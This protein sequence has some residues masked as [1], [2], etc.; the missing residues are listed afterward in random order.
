[1]KRLRLKRCIRLVQEK[2]SE[3]LVEQPP[4]ELK[5]VNTAVVKTPRVVVKGRGAN[6]LSY[7][8]NIRSHDASFGIGPAGT[9]KTYRAVA[10]AVEALEHEDGQRIILTRPAVEAGERLSFLPGDLA[11]KIDPYLRP[12]NDALS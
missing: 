8:H 3:V 6:Q 9:G 10:W 2:A 12:L 7:Q 5:G 4:A 11:Q 1:M